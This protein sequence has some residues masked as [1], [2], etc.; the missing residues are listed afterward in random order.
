M[1]GLLYNFNI[2][3]IYRKQTL[4]LLFL[5]NIFQYLLNATALIYKLFLYYIFYE[6]I[7]QNVVYI[8]KNI[9]LNNN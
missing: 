9:L 6:N 5:T 4:F 8:L 1:D 3:N 2:I 7:F